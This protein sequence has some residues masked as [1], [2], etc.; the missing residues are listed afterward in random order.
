MDK[1]RD[2][3]EIDMRIKKMSPKIISCRAAYMRAVAVHFG[4]SPADLSG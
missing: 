4:K 2:Q 3:M 1:L